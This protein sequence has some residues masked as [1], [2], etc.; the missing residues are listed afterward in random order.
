MR[1]ATITDIH[2]SQY[3]ECITTGCRN[4]IHDTSYWEIC[5]DCYGKVPEYIPLSQANFY[6]KLKHEKDKI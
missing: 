5:I 2:A 1:I 6:A 3:K 4:K